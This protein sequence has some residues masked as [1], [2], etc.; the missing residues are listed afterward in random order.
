MA[1]KCGKKGQ[2]NVFLMKNCLFSL[3][4]KPEKWESWWKYEIPTLQCY[5]ESERAKT[6]QTSTSF[7]LFRQC[8]WT[9]VFSF[10]YTFPYKLRN[11][12]FSTP[13]RPI[14][15]YWWPNFQNIWCPIPKTRY[16]GDVKNPY[17][18]KSIEPAHFPPP[19]TGL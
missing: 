8:F 17:E 3:W 12:T 2:K 15:K 5:S 18:K 4:G 7:C 16:I 6:I 9:M 1:D 19:G 10:P 14:K 11:R 13:E